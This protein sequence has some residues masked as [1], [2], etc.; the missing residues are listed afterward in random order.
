MAQGHFE[1][2]NTDDM[3]DRMEDLLHKVCEAGLDSSDVDDYKW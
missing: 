1:E 2:S 3:H